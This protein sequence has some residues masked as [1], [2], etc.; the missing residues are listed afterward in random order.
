MTE[1]KRQYVPPELRDLSAADGELQGQCTSGPKPYIECVVGPDPAGE[2]VPCT[3][4]AFETEPACQ[5]GGSAAT[6]CITGAAQV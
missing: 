6:I 1:K 2:L 3:F 4:G 5:V